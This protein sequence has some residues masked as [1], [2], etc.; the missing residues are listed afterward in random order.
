MDPELRVQRR[1]HYKVPGG[2]SNGGSMATPNPRVV[3]GSSVG[4][5]GNHLEI[6][7]VKDK[8]GKSSNVEQ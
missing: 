3:P 7:D 2:S 4:V 1:T 8:E 5:N 6:L